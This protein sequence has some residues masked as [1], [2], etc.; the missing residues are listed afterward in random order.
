MTRYYLR[1]KYVGSSVY[2]Q[3]DSD[4]YGEG[5]YNNSGAECVGGNIKEIIISK[6]S[7][8][9]YGLWTNMTVQATYD[10]NGC[11]IERPSGK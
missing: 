11:G 8:S 4:S 10:Y 3:Y 9:S 7:W 5:N 6:S 1:F 2:N